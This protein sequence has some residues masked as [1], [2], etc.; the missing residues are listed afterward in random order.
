MIG[1]NGAGKST[2]MKMIFGL[3][4]PTTGD[5][6]FA[7]EKITGLS[8]DRIVRRGMAYVPQVENV[9]P[10]LTVRET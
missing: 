7:G 4:K 2:L 3:L 9:F 5:V 10:S 8:P 6:F 1:P